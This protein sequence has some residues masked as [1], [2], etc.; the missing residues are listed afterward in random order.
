[1]KLLS[2]KTKK[3]THRRQ[4]KNGRKVRSRIVM[5]GRNKGEKRKVKARTRGEG[6]RKKG[7]GTRKKEKGKKNI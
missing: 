2:E 6:K 4:K 1:M 5:E 7:E 3:K